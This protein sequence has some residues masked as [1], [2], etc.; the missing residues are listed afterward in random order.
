MKKSNRIALVSAIALVLGSIGAANAVG[1]ITEIEASGPGLGS[2]SAGDLTGS[3]LIWSKTFDHFGP[4][5]LLFT[6]EHGTGPGGSPYA[7][8]ET[9]HNNTGIDFTDFHFSIVEPSA[10]NG[11]VF[12]GSTSALAGFNLDAS[13]GPRDLNFTGGT[14]F[15]G[16]GS[17][18]A[19]TLNTPD[20]GNGKTYQFELVQ[21]ASVPEP[22][23]WALMIA[24]LLGVAGI[25]RRKL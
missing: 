9:I 16:S 8:A 22:G 4:I 12:T 25:A 3:S 14:L 11:V 21:T 10:K 19:F 24:G 13:S 15:N 17:V 2:F 23:A 7:I 18:A 1:T 6:V 20:P 5:T